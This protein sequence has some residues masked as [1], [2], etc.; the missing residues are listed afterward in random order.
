[1]KTKLTSFFLILI[2]F[3]C[4]NED[5]KDGQ[6]SENENLKWAENISCPESFDKF[7]NE[8]IAICYPNDWISDNSGTFGSEVYLFS[9]VKDTFPDGRIFTQNINVMKQDESL[10][11]PYKIFNLDEFADFS[12]KQV[13]DVLYQAQ[14]LKFEKASIAGIKAY[15]CVMM[16]NQNGFDLYFNQYLLKHK[17]HYFIITYTAPEDVSDA[18]KKQAIKIMN[19]LKLN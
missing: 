5:S 8:I 18:T 12:K 6:G 3:S 13:E 11:E 10:L 17:N 1:M 4:D 14:I 15:N 2:L 9:P 16:A 7:A 19:T